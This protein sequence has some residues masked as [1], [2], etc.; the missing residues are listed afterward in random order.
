MLVKLDAFDNPLP[1]APECERLEMRVLRRVEVADGGEY[2]LAELLKPLPVAHDDLPQNITHVII[3]PRFEGTTLDGAPY[4]GRAANLA[5]LTNP[6][7]LNAAQVGVEDVFLAQ[8]GLAA[9]I[10]T[11]T[12]APA[13][14]SG[15]RS[16]FGLRRT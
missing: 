7:A 12:P 5:Y 16:L 11:K 13:K 9:A 6:A 3:S 4:G 1:G 15:W 2:W 10:P 14:K 8:I